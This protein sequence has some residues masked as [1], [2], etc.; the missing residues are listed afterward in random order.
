MDYRNADGSEAEMCGNGI[1][2]FARF[3]LDSGLAAGPQIPVATRSGTRIGRGRRRAAS[4]AS[5]WA[6]R[7]FW[8]LAQP[9][10]A[11]RP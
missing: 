1:R 2:V 6:R 9:G 7:R 8:A 3:L 5:T 4:S 11:S 10:W